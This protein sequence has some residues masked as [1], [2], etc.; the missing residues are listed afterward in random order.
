MTNPWSI[1]GRD[2]LQPAKVHRRTHT[3]TR[4]IV[5]EMRPIST[6]SSPYFLDMLQEFD[7]RWKAPNRETMAKTLLPAWYDSEREILLKD[8]SRVPYVSVTSDGWASIAQDHYLTFTAHFILDRNLKS[9][10]LQTKAVYVKQSGVNVAV[11]ILDCLKDFDITEKATIITVDNAS[12][13]DVAAEKAGMLKL[14]CFAQTLNLEA[15]KAIE[16]RRV[17]TWMNKI[18]PIIT[19]F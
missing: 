13:M 15:Q 8:L 5:K 16:T 14:G 1:A 10:V 3:V 2:K 9:K 6:I 12:N 18:R 11:E 19:W 17:V 4:Y 7:S